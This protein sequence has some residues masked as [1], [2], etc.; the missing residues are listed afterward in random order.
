MLILPS[1]AWPFVSPQMD[2]NWVR[3]D[4]FSWVTF[5]QQFTTCP[6]TFGPVTPTYNLK[7]GFIYCLHCVE[8]RFAL[9]VLPNSLCVKRYSHLLATAPHFCHSICTCY[10]NYLHPW[11]IL[12]PEKLP[13]GVKECIWFTFPSWKPPLRIPDRLLNLK[14]NYLPDTSQ[15]LNNYA[16]HGS[17]DP[18]QQGK[19][20]ITAAQRWMLGH[21]VMQR[22]CCGCKKGCNN[23]CGCVGKGVPCSSSCACGGSCGNPHN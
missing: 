13:K 19:L 7:Q 15:T 22:G 12:W 3:F 5:S 17:F 10:P 16:S 14:D 9:E 6:P 18:D 20:T 23:R 21:E 2:Q 8:I 1:T 4:H 11:T